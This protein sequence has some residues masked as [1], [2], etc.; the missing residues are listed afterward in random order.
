MTIVEIQAQIQEKSEIVVSLNTQ[1]RSLQLGLNNLRAELYSLEMSVFC[2]YLEMGEELMIDSYYS[3]NGYSKDKSATNT[4]LAGESIKILKK[5]KKSIVVAVTK[6]W[7]RK[8]DEAQKKTIIVD[9]YNPDWKIRVN[10]DSMFHFYMKSTGR[11]ERFE[12]YI[13]RN[14]VLESLFDQ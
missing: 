4:F 11:K 10:L 7:R 5:N 1:L 2:E 9:T 8:W 6:K 3:F 13:K 14:Q 12:S